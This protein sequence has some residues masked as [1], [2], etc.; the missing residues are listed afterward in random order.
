MRIKHVKLI[1]RESDGMKIRLPAGLGYQ[2]HGDF[3][4]WTHASF[5]MAGKTVEYVSHVPVTSEDVRKFPVEYVF[6]VSDS[7]FLN[8]ETVLLSN[9][10]TIYRYHIEYYEHAQSQGKKTSRCCSCAIS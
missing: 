10:E 9:G 7:E 2:T 5:C 6:K 1:S 8:P 4:H 3:R